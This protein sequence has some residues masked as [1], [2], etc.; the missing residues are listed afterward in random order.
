M[1]LRRAGTVP[2]TGV[3][4]GPGSAAHHHSASKTR[5]NALMVKNGA[6]RCVRGTTF[7]FATPI[8][9]KYLSTPGWISSSLGAAATVF[10]AVVSQACG[11]FL[12]SGLSAACND[13]ARRYATSSGRFSRASTKLQDPSE[14]IGADWFG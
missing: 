11:S 10:A 14:S 1:P 5:V 7:Y 8:S 6:L 3:R 4:Y 13:F 9:R 2:N 12:H